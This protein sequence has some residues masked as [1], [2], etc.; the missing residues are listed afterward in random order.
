MRLAQCCRDH[1]VT[2]NARRAGIG[3]QQTRNHAQRGGLSRA[4]GAKGRMELTGRGLRVEMIDG[5]FPEKCL[6]S[7]R[8]ERAGCMVRAAQTQDEG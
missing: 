3:F 1:V 2:K 6:L 4:I 8:M 5:D 7:W